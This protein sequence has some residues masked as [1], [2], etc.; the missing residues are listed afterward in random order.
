V[1]LLSTVTAKTSGA[2]CLVTFPSAKN[3][4]LATTTY[5]NVGKEIELVASVKGI[6]SLGTGS[7]CTYGLESAGVYSGR[8]LVALTNGGTLKWQ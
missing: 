3:Q 2:E 1:S 5:L 8:S 7:F 6:S 4:T